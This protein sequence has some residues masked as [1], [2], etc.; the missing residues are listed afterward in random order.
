MTGGPLG[1]GPGAKK[2]GRDLNDNPA[3]PG[4]QARTEGSLFVCSGEIFA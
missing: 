1:V 3:S 4:R 2:V